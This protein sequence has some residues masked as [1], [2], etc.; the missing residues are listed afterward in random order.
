MAKKD[1]YAILK[2]GDTNEMLE[3]LKKLSVEQIQDV[4]K[5]IN[6]FELIG[7]SPEKLEDLKKIID[8]FEDMKRQNAELKEEIKSLRE[9]VQKLA[10]AKNQIDF[11]RK[12]TNYN[13]L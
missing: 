8:Q 2:Q 11:S 5:I 4:Q 1:R 12:V 7:I 6:F 3:N 10:I 9:S 13:E